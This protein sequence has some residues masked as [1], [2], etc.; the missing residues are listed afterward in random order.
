MLRMVFQ[1][2]GIGIVTLWIA[3][4]LVFAGTEILPGDVAEIILGQEATP[5]TLAALRSELGLDKPAVVRYFEWLGD[6]ASG[7]LG[8]SKAGG[9]TIASL[10][11]DRLLNT[12]TLGGIVAGISVP[13]SILIGV[14]AAMYTGPDCGTS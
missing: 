13:L 1:R 3:S 6:L 10:I 9:A 4:V 8:I 2:V 7:D 12:V 11:A 5:E 14:L